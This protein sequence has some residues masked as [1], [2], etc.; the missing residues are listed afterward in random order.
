MVAKI[1]G[2]CQQHLVALIEDVGIGRNGQRAGIL[3]IDSDGEAT[4]ASVLR[5]SQQGSLDDDVA[6]AHLLGVAKAI[7][8]E[9]QSTKPVAAVGTIDGLADLSHVGC[10]VV[11]VGYQPRGNGRDAA[12]GGY[13]GSIDLTTVC[14]V[15]SHV[16]G[17][18]G[19]R[20]YHAL[21]GNEVEVDGVILVGGI[22]LLGWLHQR[23][24]ANGA[25][26]LVGQ[27]RAEF[28]VAGLEVG[29]HLLVG[30]ESCRLPFASLME[31]ETHRSRLV[32]QRC[33]TLGDATDTNIGQANRLTGGIAVV[34]RINPH[35]ELLSAFKGHYRLCLHFVH[36]VAGH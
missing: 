26:A 15:A 31:R 10:L 21:L 24:L 14:A 35:F 23:L 27:R 6:E 28:H 30:T 3:V 19:R 11:A 34:P 17:N 29:A 2:N 18:P 8:I 9:T 16:E 7:E 33:T 32:L 36:G 25:N 13:P 12:V 20:E 1:L 22:V 4:L 5:T